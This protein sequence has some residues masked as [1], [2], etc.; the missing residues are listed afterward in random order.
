MRLGVAMAV[1]VG[2]GLAVSAAHAIEPDRLTDP[3]AALLDAPE[4]YDVGNGA[5]N[6]LSTFMQLAA[7]DGFDV[8]AVTG[9]DWDTVTSDDT[10][11]ILYP[12]NELDSLNVKAFVRF[13]GKLILG[14]DFGNSAKALTSLGIVRE[15]GL[16]VGASEFYDDLPFAP[17]ATP[18]L[19]H[20]LTIGVTN[21]VTNHPAVI[22]NAGAATPIF[23]FSD[24][25]AVVVAGELGH[26]RY[27]VISD[28]SVLINGMLHHAGNFQ[29]AL[30]L[31][32]YFSPDKTGRVIVLAGE[33]SL[34]GEPG[35]MVSD[36]SFEGALIDI[37]NFLDEINGWTLHH[38][39]MRFIA[40]IGGLLL[41]LLASAALP[42]KKGT[43]LDGTWL[44]ARPRE[45]EGARRIGGDFEAVLAKFDDDRHRGSYLLPAAILRD[46]I[47]LRLA[48]TLEIE[49]PMAT[50]T[51]T[52]LLER[53][54][55][56]RGRGARDALAPL[57]GRLQK[58]PS[59]IGAETEWAGRWVP[60][61]EF[62][63]MHE[64]ARL[65]YGALDAAK[66]TA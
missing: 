40:V 15:W 1:G 12:L 44:R 53:I 51:A 6:G 28:P 14:D 33:F 17:I 36:S 10:L 65:F 8:S 2:L 58:L 27:V 57:L 50:Y 25:E 16:G 38:G 24:G 3:G 26:G 9:I 4:D 18:L 61:R 41:A 19:G 31:L 23:G 66:E 43:A 11:V 29:F 13:G 42:L 54:E 45:L 5:W 48:T 21:L 34:R 55:Q 64:E 49:H 22:V 47:D 52:E 63:R 62:E 32:R 59:R 60:K 56:R 39:A 7:G 35:R 30:N 37:N 46:A 20:P